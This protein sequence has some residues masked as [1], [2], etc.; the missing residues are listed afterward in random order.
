MDDTVEKLPLSVVGGEQVHGS[1]TSW[2]HLE[3]N[4]AETE[5]QVTLYGDASPETLME[6]TGVANPD[7]D[8]TVRPRV[9]VSAKGP[10]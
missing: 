4:A 8:A 6:S 10:P 7:V 2:V 3:V 9:S 1:A 5:D